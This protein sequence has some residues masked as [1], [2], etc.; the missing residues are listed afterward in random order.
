MAGQEN[1]GKGR[2]GAGDSGAAPPSAGWRVVAILTGLGL[3]AVLVALWAPGQGPTITTVKEKTKTTTPA[4]AQG[5]GKPPRETV[6]RTEKTTETLNGPE[7]ARK[8]AGAPQ[9]VSRRS[10][11]LAVALVPAAVLLLF[12]GA[13]AD[14]L[15]SLSAPGGWKLDF[16]KPTVKEAAKVGATVAQTALPESVEPAMALALSR[17]EDRKQG[18]LLSSPP[19]RG[20]FRRSAR[21]PGITLGQTSPSDDYLERIAT[22]AVETVSRPADPDRS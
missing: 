21:E 5:E 22:E 12:A 9:P 2:G 17:L 15:A 19:R 4:D 18:I 7:S 1:A 14:R 11:T 6:A 13:F 16:I 3:I 8:D 20:L 10:E